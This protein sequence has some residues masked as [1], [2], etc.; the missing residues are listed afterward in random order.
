MVEGLKHVQIHGSSRSQ[1]PTLSERRSSF[2]K[3]AI[4]FLSKPGCV[5][6][7]KEDIVGAAM[8]KEHVLYKNSVVSFE[9]KIDSEFI[10]LVESSGG[11]LHLHLKSNLAQSGLTIEDLRPSKLEK[12][13]KGDYKVTL[14]NVGPYEVKIPAGFSL[15]LG[16]PYGYKPAEPGAFDMTAEVENLKKV[17]KKNSG[18][19]NKFKYIAE[20]S[21]IGIRMEKVLVYPKGGKK[22]ILDEN[23]PRGTKRKELHEY[24]GIEEIEA[25]KNDTFKTLC[26]RFGINAHTEDYV[27]IQTNGPI[28]YPEGQGVLMTGGAIDRGESYTLFDHGLS[29]LGQHRKHGHG[30][31]DPE[32]ALIGEFHLSPLQI[33]EH[34]YD[35]KHSVYLRAVP[36]NLKWVN[37]DGFF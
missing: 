8:K 5:L 7:Q 4:K 1:T 34:I 29:N 10:S 36:V 23:F 37:K 21:E 27:L 31:K 9:V 32:H 24:L 30:S 3:E 25:R 17:N 2:Q 11:E 26:K 33:L 6:A 12:A 35:K 14:K 13:K 22:I 20:T 15:P 28:H 19:N 18:K 16:N